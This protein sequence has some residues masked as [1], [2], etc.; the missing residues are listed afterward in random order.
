MGLSSRQVKSRGHKNDVNV[1]LYI[2]NRHRLKVNTSFGSSIALLFGG[3]AVIH[4]NL[5]TRIKSQLKTGSHCLT[6]HDAN[7]YYIS[8]VPDRCL[9]LLF[10]SSSSQTLH[11]F[12]VFTEST[13]SIL[14]NL[15]LPILGIVGP[16]SGSLFLWWHSSAP[17]LQDK[18][19][20]H[21]QHDYVRMRLIYVN[22]Q[23][24]FVDMQHN[25]S[26]M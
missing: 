17:Y 8:T 6:S 20:Q 26:R 3:I 9:S 24:D 25:L 21:S 12:G 16:W 23:H 18:L 4:R 22:M 5:Y 11:G 1:I 14:T 10:A 13:G 7:F 19:C 15:K 2:I